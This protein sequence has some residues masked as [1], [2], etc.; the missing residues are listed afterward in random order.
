MQW[1]PDGY[2][3]AGG[4]S[5]RMGSEKGLI[6]VH[7]RYLIEYVIANLKNA[8][9]DI[10]I[11][12]DNTEY[13][14]FGCEVIGDEVKNEGPARGIAAAMK[15]AATGSFFVISC[16][17]PFIHTS[18]IQT[19][20]SMSAGADITIPR[21]NGWMEPLCGVYTASCYG[22]WNALVESGI[23]KM[24]TLIENFN[25]RTLDAGTVLLA[26]EMAFMNVNTPEDLKLAILKGKWR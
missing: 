15:H 23:H 9:G 26:D 1:K 19:I 5:S 17:T 8:V 16:D 4:R 25:Y 21:L 22:K 24:Q 18:L 6:Q 14:K 12:S 7:G 20:I 11:C 10:F 2:I 13:R 3:L